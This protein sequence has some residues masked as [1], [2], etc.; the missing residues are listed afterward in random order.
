MGFFAFALPEERRRTYQLTDTYTRDVNGQGIRG[1]EGVTEDDEMVRGFNS[2]D[3]RTGAGLPRF[4][5]IGR[6]DGNRSASC[7]HPA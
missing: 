2:S 3:R 5:G 6:P 1:K 4:P 7:R